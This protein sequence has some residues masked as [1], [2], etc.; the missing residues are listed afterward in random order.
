MCGLKQSGL[1]LHR[2]GEC[3]LLVAEQLTFNQGGD[4]RTAVHGDEGTAGK[5]SA[6]M[7]GARHQLFAR[8]AFAAI[9]TAYVFSA[10]SW[11]KR[12]LADGPTDADRV[13]L[14]STRHRRRLIAPGQDLLRHDRRQKQ[15]TQF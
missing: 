7:D 6:E 11:R 14:I 5:N 13:D 12:P 8:A 2:P 9:R 10:A 4:Q 1:G 3:A 15:R